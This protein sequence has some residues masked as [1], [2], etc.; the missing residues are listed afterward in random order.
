MSGMWNFKNKG[1]SAAL[2]VIVVLLS[3]CAANLLL[4][5]HRSLNVSAV[6]A[7]VSLG[8]YWDANCSSSVTSIDWGSLIPG[9]GSSVTFY[10]RNE[11]GT[12]CVLL[13]SIVNWQGNN[14]SNCVSFSCA[15]PTIVPAAT[16]RVTPSLLVFSNASAVN[17]NFGML[18]VGVSV[19]ISDFDTLFGSNTNVKIIYPSTNSSKPLGC[20]AAM[21]SD[22]TASAF[23][24]TKLNNATEG[25]DT[26][27][28]YVNQSTGRA[29]GG[30]GAGIVSFGGSLVNPVV[31]YAESSGTVQSDRAPLMYAS[32]GGTCYFRFA[33]GSSIAGASL[34]V[35]V[36]NVNQ[37]MF[38][39]EVY[40]DGSARYVLLCYGFGWQGTYAAGK[41]FDGVLYPNLGSQSESWIIVKWVDSNGN[42]FVNGPFD[43]DTY[44][45]IAQ[46]N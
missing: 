15:A 9:Q 4:G 14:A 10:V 37:D 12:D 45:V 13:V 20:G 1:R 3:T 43:G 38:L 21:V 11:G 35:S 22:W 42:G 16:V 33:N 8:V 7:T 31:K 40:A 6:E 39:I 46:G 17:F 18:L 19:A 29:L 36:I 23:V 25:L 41:Y 28:S 30:S 5:D 27:A 34:P 32:S 44:T 24:S 26:Q 2:L